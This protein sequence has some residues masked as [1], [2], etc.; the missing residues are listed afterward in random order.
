MCIVPRRP[1]F[2]NVYFPATEAVIAM[3][4]WKADSIPA[5]QAA[6]MIVR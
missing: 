1:L 3:Y 5:D 4:Y 6:V 2:C